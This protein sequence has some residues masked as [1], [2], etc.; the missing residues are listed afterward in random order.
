MY[1]E[2]TGEGA[3]VLVFSHGLLMDHTMFAPQAEAFKHR[4]RC[5]SWDERGHGRTANSETCEPFSYYD[6]ADDLAALLDYLG[7]QR[8]ILV[9]MSQGGYLSLRAA[10]KHSMIVQA[11]VLI[12][13]Q[14]GPEDP[15]K[16]PGYAVMI[17]DWV[18][19]GLSDQTAA[20]LEHII[21]GD[22]WGGAAAW[23]EK[24]A[25]WQS[26]N[27]LQCFHTL[28]SRD[29][30]RD[31]LGTINV[32]VL[33]IHGDVDVAIEPERARAMTDAMPNACMERIVGG[34][35]ASNLTHPDRVNPLIEAFVS[36]LS[37]PLHHMG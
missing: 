9:G 24:W 19:H 27:L 8:A 29:D 3:S 31:M 26:H 15:A 6:S 22:G 37:R 13:T 23:R 7:I 18:T 11:M 33:V 35:H 10:I 36:Q 34:G 20:I 16:M 21:L 12:D 4:Y 17:N 1:Y 30:I 14:A 32:P 28:G 5:I 25:A 2:D